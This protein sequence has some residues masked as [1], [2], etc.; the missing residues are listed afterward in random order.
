LG[1]SSR[2]GPEFCPRFTASEGDLFVS[3]GKRR[4]ILV[5]AQNLHDQMGSFKCQY[6]LEQERGISHEKLA[7]RKENRI[8][9]GQSTS[10]QSIFVDFSCEDM[11]FE[12]AGPGDGNGTATARFDIVWS[13]IGSP[14][15][16]TIFHPLDNAQGMKVK[17]YKCQQL[18][19]NC[20]LCLGLDSQKFDCGW[21][22]EEGRCVPKDMCQN[23]NKHSTHFPIIS[24][25]K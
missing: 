25:Q 11:L 2:R 7:E 17:I 6:T 24:L 14:T 8:M 5:E 9:Y 16:S 12:F 21:C 13:P 1:P 19:P 22:E 18:A 15:T 3:S 23:G 4:T 20:G 10:N